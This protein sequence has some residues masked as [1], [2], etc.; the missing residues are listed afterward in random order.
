M[1]SSLG[2]C[3]AGILVS[4]DLDFEITQLD[5]PRRDSFMFIDDCFDKFA[6][7]YSSKYP[8]LKSDLGIHYIVQERPEGCDSFDYLE[9]VLG[10]T[11][12]TNFFVKSN[13]GFQSKT[14]VFPLNL[15]EIAADLNLFIET[16]KTNLLEDFISDEDASEYEYEQVEVDKEELAKIQ[17]CPP[18][19]PRLFASLNFDHLFDN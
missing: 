16:Y 10:Q 1:G 12:N 5:D 18:K 17:K 6:E 11:L 9:L 15:N 8:K 7:V 19:V 13:D 2:S 4:L 3:V 14:I